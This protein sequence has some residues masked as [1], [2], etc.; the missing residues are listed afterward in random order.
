MGVSTDV[1]V[2]ISEDCRSIYRAGSGWVSVEYQSSIGH[3]STHV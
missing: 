2:D 3:V 1:A